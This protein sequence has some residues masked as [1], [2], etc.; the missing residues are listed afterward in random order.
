MGFVL[1]LPVFALHAISETQFSGAYFCTAL[2]TSPFQTA[3]S[4]SC[5]ASLLDKAVSPR[6]GLAPQ[7]PGKI[8]MPCYFSNMYTTPKAPF[9]S[10]LR[11]IIAKKPRNPTCHS[12][13]VQQGPRFEEPSRGPPFAMARRATTKLP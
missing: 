4:F 9:C 7:K 1:E 8:T 5:H 10:E 11:V 3:I 12:R 6:R 2:D 13:A